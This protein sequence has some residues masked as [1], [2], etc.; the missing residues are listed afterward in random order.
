MNP[1]PDLL[2]DKALESRSKQP[3]HGTTAALAAFMLGVPGAMTCSAVSVYLAFYWIAGFA[4]EAATGLTI[5]WGTYLTLMTA[6]WF[7][8][9]QND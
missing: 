4:L 2:A 7:A 5:L 6:L 9:A 1:N 8:E 3:E